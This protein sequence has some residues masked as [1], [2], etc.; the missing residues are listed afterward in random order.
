MVLKFKDTSYLQS[1]PACVYKN[2]FKILEAV[3]FLNSFMYV[4]KPYN[5]K[6]AI[7]ISYLVINL[8]GVSCVFS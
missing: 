5:D 1:C 4:H 7:N 8:R 6:K 2:F 3:L